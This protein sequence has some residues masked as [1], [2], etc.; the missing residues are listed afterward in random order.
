MLAKPLLAFS[1]YC[2]LFALLAIRVEPFW[3]RLT[4]IALAVLSL[5]ALLLIFRLDSKS[6]PVHRTIDTIKQPGAE[7][8]GYLASYLLPFVI[9]PDPS[10][11]DLIAYGLF[12]V[13]AGVVT[14]STGAIQVNPLIYLT[15]RRIVRMTDANG[16]NELAIIRGNLV[17]GDAIKVTLL[18][19]DV[20]VMR[21]KANQG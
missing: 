12:L 6:T 3:L 5:G 20:V 18:Q 15:R 8:G 19:G 7:A 2:P 4:L 21:G 10:L 17:K 11:P 16:S 1:S 9:S 14:A 13:I